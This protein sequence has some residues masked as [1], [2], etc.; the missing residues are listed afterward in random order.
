MQELIDNLKDAARYLLQNGQTRQGLAVQ[1]CVTMLED[2]DDEPLTDAA[3]YALADQHG[4]RYRTADEEG[5]TFDKHAVLGFARE[6]L[7]WPVMV[8]DATAPGAPPSAEWRCSQLCA[9]SDCAE[10]KKCLATRG[11]QGVGRG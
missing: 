5:M 2:D 3:I 8:D 4:T 10:V 9:R 11:M 6:L 1:A 7:L